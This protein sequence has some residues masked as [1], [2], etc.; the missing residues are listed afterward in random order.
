MM[1]EEWMLAEAEIRE[2]TCDLE[3][4]DIAALVEML[5][6]IDRRASQA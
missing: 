1:A 4:A 3:R 5:R 6:R 2:V